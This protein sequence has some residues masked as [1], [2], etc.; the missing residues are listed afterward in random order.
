MVQEKSSSA[1]YEKWRRTI[2]F[3]NVQ[4]ELAIRQEAASSRNEF[5]KRRTLRRA[6]HLYTTGR[7]TR[8][9]LSTALPRLVKYCSVC[10]ATALYRIGSSGRCREHRSVGL[11][12]ARVQY[13]R[14]SDEQSA[15][16]D[17]TQQR[18]RL[19]DKK[20]RHTS[21]ARKSRVKDRRS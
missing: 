17:D 2:P 4:I 9:A 15:V 12:D 3:T 11:V 6:D 14:R 21:S 1:S 18:I 10:G 8:R 13:I 20:Q 19:L 5:L 7:L 16:I